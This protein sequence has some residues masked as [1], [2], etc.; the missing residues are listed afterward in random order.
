MGWWGPG[1][2]RLEEGTGG[3]AAV[4]LGGRG[5]PRGGSPRKGGGEIGGEGIGGKG[6]G[7]EGIGGEGIG[8][9]GRVCGDGPGG[10]AGGAAGQGRAG[11]WGVAISVKWASGEDVMRRNG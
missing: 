10:A 3:A 7:G 4:W 8:G 5:G 1:W 6:I 2:E 9:E 11:D